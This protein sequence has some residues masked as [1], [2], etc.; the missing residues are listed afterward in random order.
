M[1]TQKE[2]HSHPY[3]QSLNDMPSTPCTTTP[4]PTG[5][6]SP[7]PSDHDNDPPKPPTPREHHFFP[8]RGPSVTEILARLDRL[9]KEQHRNGT[10]FKLR[11][12]DNEEDWVATPDPHAQLT[13]IIPSSPALPPT[14]AEQI[15]LE[16]LFEPADSQRQPA[17]PPDIGTRKRKSEYSTPERKRP[18]ISEDNSARDIGQAVRR[19]SKRPTR[20]KRAPKVTSGD[21]GVQPSDV[22]KVEDKEVD[23]TSSYEAVQNGENGDLLESSPGLAQQD[24]ESLIQYGQ[25]KNAS[26][27]TTKHITKISHPER[28][29]RQKAKHQKSGSK[30]ASTERSNNS[31]DTAKNVPDLLLELDGEPPAATPKMKPRRKTRQSKQPGYAGITKSQSTSNTRKRASDRKK[32]PKQAIKD[33][34]YKPTKPE[35]HSRSDPFTRLFLMEKGFELTPE[36]KANRKN[37]EENG[38]DNWEE[39]LKTM[40]L[41][42]NSREALKQ[43]NKETEE[44]CRRKKAAEAQNR[45]SQCVYSP[46]DD[47]GFA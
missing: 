9:E 24:S 4:Q 25:Y 34:P 44:E 45:T 23:E 31:Q 26:V 32:K 17:R 38:W 40:I 19:R 43:L 46:W 22:T 7:S 6:L 47:S 37:L 5:L 21:E 27:T 12:D 29:R 41:I 35:T 18:R 20:N 28:E 3:Y 15:F 39:H 14:K 16:A 8:T 42:R 1:A 36:G 10:V 11:W 13:P 2:K 30:H 33:E